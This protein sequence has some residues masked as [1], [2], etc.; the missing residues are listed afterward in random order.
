MGRGQGTRTRVLAGFIIDMLN[1]Q[2]A[3]AGDSVVA[4]AVGI[5]SLLVIL[6]FVQACPSLQSFSDLHS[7]NAHC[8][9]P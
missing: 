9:L 8:C 5:T 2:A 3:A 7:G 1:S 6:R 4:F